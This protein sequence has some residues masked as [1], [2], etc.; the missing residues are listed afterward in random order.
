MRRAR[1]LAATSQVVIAF[2]RIVADQ[3]IVVQRAPPV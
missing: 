2:R 1:T 3:E